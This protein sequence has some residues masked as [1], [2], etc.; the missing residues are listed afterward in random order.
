MVLVYLIG[1]WM[2]GGWK[3]DYN[4]GLAYLT[5]SFRVGYVDATGDFSVYG[6]EH[7][8]LYTGYSESGLAFL[9]NSYY[10]LTSPGIRPVICL[11]SNVILEEVGENEYDIRLAE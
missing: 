8:W 1:C 3:V 11:K 6:K 10:Y 2:I 5:S 7:W 9:P 4:G